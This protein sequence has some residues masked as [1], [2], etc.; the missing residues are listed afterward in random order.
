MGPIETISSNFGNSTAGREPPR[1]QDYGAA[2]H[3]LNAS[4]AIEKVSMLPSD[5][6]TD[7]QFENYIGIMLSLVANPEQPE[8]IRTQVIAI[9]AN[10]SLRDKLRR[11][12]VS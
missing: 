3:R 6:K 11:V 7:S 2:R 12:L 8:Q 10:L 1:H 9:L 4:M 5:P